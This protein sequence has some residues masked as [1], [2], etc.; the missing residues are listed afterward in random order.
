MAV[1]KTKFGQF[2]YRS[3]EG[4]TKLFQW[5]IQSVA[6]ISMV[7]LFSIGFLKLW[8]SV[9]RYKEIYLFLRD[10]LH[11]LEI[12]FIAPIPVLIVF[13]FK[14]YLM[15]IF[16]TE[17]LNLTKVDKIITTIEAKKA[18]ITSLIGITSTFILGIFIDHLSGNNKENIYLF[19]SND[20]LIIL[21]LAIL[22]LIIQIILFYIISKYNEEKENTE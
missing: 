22:F 18:F 2:V 10:I 12:L 6:I 11:S 3:I 20:Y 17:I 15:S 8:V 13:S 14:K 16:N 5:L 9:Y 19:L 7:V 21:T 1:F 4:L